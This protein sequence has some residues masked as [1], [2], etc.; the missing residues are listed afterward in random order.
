MLEI[1]KDNYFDR[2][3]T[4][5]SMLCDGAKEDSEESDY[6]GVCLIKIGNISDEELEAII[7]VMAEN[8]C[9]YW[10]GEPRIN[11]EREYELWVEYIPDDE[12]GELRWGLYPSNYIIRRG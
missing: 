8:N 2:Y 12:D 4:I 3:R 11:P 1:I 9:R 10:C 7:S 6:V 5:V